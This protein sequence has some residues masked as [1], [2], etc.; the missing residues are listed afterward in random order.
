[1]RVW[2]ALGAV[3]A[4]L[5]IGCATM[6]VPATGVQQLAVDDAPAQVLP[7]SPPWGVVTVEMRKGSSSKSDIRQVPLQDP[8]FVQQALQ[9]S[10]VTKRFRGMNIQLIRVVGD[11]RQ[12]MDSKYDRG[13]GSVEPAYDYALRPGDHLIVTEDNTTSLDMM[14]RS[15]AGPLG[16]AVGK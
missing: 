8:M 5:Q 16:R 3:G 4:T 9:A 6:A 12:K 11:D 13:K 10:G 7:G 15:L 2:L 14:F 1:L